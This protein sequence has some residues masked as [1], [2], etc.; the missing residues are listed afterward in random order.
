MTVWREGDGLVAQL[1]GAPKFPIF[2]EAP[3]SF[4]WKVVNA[5]VRFTE[6]SGKVT[7]AVLTQDGQA[8]KGKKAP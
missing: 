6:E 7:G 1:S 8:Y 3:L 2:A 5:D 4:F